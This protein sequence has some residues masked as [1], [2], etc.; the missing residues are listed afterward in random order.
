MLFR[1]V[2]FEVSVF[3]CE[4]FKCLRIYGDKVGDGLDCLDGGEKFVG[5]WLR[6]EGADCVGDVAVGGEE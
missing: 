4:D 6:R 2:E 3:V 1:S 5:S